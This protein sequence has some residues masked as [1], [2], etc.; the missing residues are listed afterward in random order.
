[1][2]VEE[3]DEKQTEDTDNLF[4]GTVAENVSRESPRCR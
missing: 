4:N 3:G 2:D 1:M